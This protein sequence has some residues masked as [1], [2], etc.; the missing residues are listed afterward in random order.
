M[1]YG[2]IFMLFLVRK[3]VILAIENTRRIKSA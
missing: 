3:N 1:R 2:A